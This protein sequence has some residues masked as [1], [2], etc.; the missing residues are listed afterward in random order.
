MSEVIGC[1]AGEEAG[2]VLGLFCL[3]KKNLIKGG[4]PNQA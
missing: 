1:S 2:V 3:T 4:C